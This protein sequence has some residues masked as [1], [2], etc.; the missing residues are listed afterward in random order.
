VAVERRRGQ[1]SLGAHARVLLVA[2]CVALSV[3]AVW[4]LVGNQ[5]LFAGQEALTRKDWSAARQHA[6]R[7]QSLLFWSA[8]PELVL[9]D[10]EAGL[11][12]RQAALQAYR[13]AVSTDPQSWVAWLRVAQVARGSE[14]AEAY[15]RVRQLNPREEGLPGA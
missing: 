9:G 14:R 15:R 2:V 12:N 8:E 7:A 6:R 1:W 11:G 10:A 4:S 5:A 13:D 3:C